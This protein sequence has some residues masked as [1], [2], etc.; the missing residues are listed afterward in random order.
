MPVCNALNNHMCITVAGSWRPCCRFN[1]FPHVD[2]TQTSFTDYKQSDF[3]QGVIYDMTDGWA[4]GCKKCMKE[5]QR[6]HNSLRE[7]MNEN[8]SG[9]TDLEYIEISLSNKC[10][11]ACKMCAPTYSTLWNKLVEQ[12]SQ[13][14]K[15]HHTVVQPEISVPSI[16]ADVDLS[17]LKKIKYLGGEPFITP[18]TKQLFEY[19]A[20]KNVIGNIELEL[21]TN[22]TFFPNK[23]LK[24]LDQFKAVTIELSIDGVELVNDYVRHGKTWNTVDTVT[25]QW[26]EYSANTSVDMAVYST[27]QAYNLHDMKR[28][29]QYATDLGFKHYSSLLVVPEFLSVHVLPQEYLNVIKDDYNI[30]YYKSIEQNN[31]FDKFIDFT[32]NID[33]VTGLQLKDVN[34][35]LYKYMEEHYEYT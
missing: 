35:E 23:W 15:Y 18:E 2:I 22:C 17:K 10:N 8:F 6:G 4:D 32:Y 19:L 1:N 9:T 28:V 12:N 26:A 24:Y 7:Q 25:K 16:F 20:D 13:L 27:V 11:L 30:K 3:Y 21:N 33:K 29:K 14:K 31:L 5:E 34:M